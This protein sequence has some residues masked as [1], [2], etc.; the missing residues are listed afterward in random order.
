MLGSGKILS[1]HSFCFFFPYFS[2]GCPLSIFH[3]PPLHLSSSPDLLKSTSRSPSILAVHS[4][5]LASLMFFHLSLPLSLLVCLHPSLPCGLPIFTLLLTNLPVELFCCITYFLRS[6][7][8]LSSTLFVRVIRQNQN[9]PCSCCCSVNATVSSYRLRHA[10]VTHAL[11]TFLFS[12]FKMFLSNMTPSTFPRAFAP[13]CIR[14]RI[15]TSECSSSLTIPP[16]YTKPS[17]CLNSLSSKLMFNPLSDVKPTS[18]L[19]SPGSLS[20]RAS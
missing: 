8:L 1:S 3:L 13:C 4:P 14:H 11:R 9:Q 16:S 5:F 6:F 18:L 12:F 7:V 2:N 20:V 17:T 10:C 15:S 19:S